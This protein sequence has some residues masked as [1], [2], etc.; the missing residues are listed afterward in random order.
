VKVVLKH[1]DARV[2][3]WA[4]K[5]LETTWLPGRGSCIGLEEDGQVI[6]GVLFDSFN[7]ASMC[8]HIA[9][10]PGKRWLNREFLWLCFAYPFL[11][12]RVNK[13]FGPVAE[14]NL[15][16]RRFCEKLGFVLEATLSDA[17]P[18]GGLLIYSMTR[19]QCRWLRRSPYVKTGCPAP[20]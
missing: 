7:G 1:E 5:R 2:G 14:G 20:T 13:V 18:S 17:H 6:A 10:I 4:C 12:L 19:S 16:S 8:M 9:A 15:Q 11:Q 3:P